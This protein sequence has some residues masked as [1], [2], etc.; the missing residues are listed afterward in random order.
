[1]LRRSHLAIGAG[2]TSIA[3]LQLALCPKRKF[4]VG[5]FV[6]LA[7]SVG[8]GAK[9]WRVLQDEP[10]GIRTLAIVERGEERAYV[11]SSRRVAIH[12]CVVL[13]LVVQARPR[14]ASHGAT[15]DIDRRAANMLP[16][17][18]AANQCRINSAPYCD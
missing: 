8:V 17:L 16:D 5:R 2:E 14:T 3:Q 12:R 6:I 13:A 10:L 1:M 11:L 7:L 15:E 4:A 9:V 18:V